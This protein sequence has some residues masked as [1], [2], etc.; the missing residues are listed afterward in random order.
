[1]QYLEA[2]QSGKNDWWRYLLG[3]IFILFSWLFVGAIPIVALGVFAVLDGNPATNM[4]A[5]GMVNG[6]NPFWSFL[7]LLLSFA[8]LF[9]AVPLTVRFLHGR[10]LTSLVTAATK[11]RWKRLAAGYA[12]WFALSGL[13]A[14]VEAWLYPGRYTITKDISGFPFF[15]VGIL[16]LIPIQTSAEELFFRGYVVQNIGR[17]LKNPLALSLLSGL[18]FAL[19]HIL[20]P[21][22]SVNFW[23][24]MLF[25]FTFGFFAAFISLKDNGLELAL[26][27]HAANNM[28]SGWIATYPEG[29]LPTPAIFT[30]NE[31]DPVYGLVAP[32]AAMA[33]FYGV[34]LA[35]QNHKTTEER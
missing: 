24:V 27:M 11:I 34:Y 31:L 35:L 28:F 33:V 7:A 26:G 18:L 9:L 10:S 17:R 21:E 32:L 13:V 2:A 5:S 14:L 3:Y 6:I 15:A 20:N 23:L 29:A 22:V 30:I 1:M 25:Y 4:T 8:P 19:P 12:G 16:L